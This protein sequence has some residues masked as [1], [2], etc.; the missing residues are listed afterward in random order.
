MTELDTNWVNWA[1]E[2]VARGVDDT[3]LIDAMVGADI[4]RKASTALL[5]KVRRLPGYE[6]LERITRKCQ[7]LEALV[8]LE[9]KTDPLT[10][11]TD[12]LPVEFI[13]E[14]NTHVDAQTSSRSNFS[15]WPKDLLRSSGV[16]LVYDFPKEMS[17][18]IFEHAKV[19][20]PE[21]NEF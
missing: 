3:T 21:L 10:Q 13:K 5:G 15:C 20:A 2:N 17:D 8:A 1:I 19:F 6:V 16:V 9:G 7:R 4:D 12:A 14:I 11:H 18:K